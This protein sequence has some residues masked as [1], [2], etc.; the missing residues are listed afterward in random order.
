MQERIQDDRGE[1]VGDE[2]RREEANGRKNGRARRRRSSRR[3]AEQRLGWAI[4]GVRAE[5]LTVRSLA[6][7][8]QFAVTCTVALGE[9]R[10]R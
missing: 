1:E 7:S 8:L 10:G 4:R 6:A 3:L 2:V 5:P 9:S